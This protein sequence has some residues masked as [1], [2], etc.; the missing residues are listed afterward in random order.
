MP[1]EADC[2]PGNAGAGEE[3]REIEFEDVA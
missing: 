1:G 3:G 2:H